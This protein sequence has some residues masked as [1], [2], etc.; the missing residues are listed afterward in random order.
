MGI[1]GSYQHGDN[2]RDKGKTGKKAKCEQGGTDYFCKYHEC[3]GRYRANAEG[4]GKLDLLTAKK[5]V[6][7][8]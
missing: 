4:V 7:F 3:Q 6:N 5:A 8:S 1:E 2:E